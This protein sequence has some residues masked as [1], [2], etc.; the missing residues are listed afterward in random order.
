MGCPVV[1]HLFFFVCF[2]LFWLF[3]FSS[4]VLML[5]FP[6]A[7]VTTQKASV[8]TAADDIQNIFLKLLTFYLFK[9]IRLNISYKLTV[10]NPGPAELGYVLTLQTVWIQ[11]SQPWWLSQMC[12][13]LLISWSRV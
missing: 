9:N 4:K 13:R 8:T 5:D 6:K 10:I 2:F 11:V 7:T 1:I 12:I 3:Y